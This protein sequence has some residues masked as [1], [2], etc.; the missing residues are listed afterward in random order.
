[1]SAMDR[2]KKN[3][4]R[5]EVVRLLAGLA[6]LVHKELANPVKVPDDELQAIKD[7]YSPLYTRGMLEGIVLV[8]NEMNVIEDVKK[9]AKELMGGTT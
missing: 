4:T 1:M 2:G 8:I 9:M 7:Q 5:K 3:Y 6:V